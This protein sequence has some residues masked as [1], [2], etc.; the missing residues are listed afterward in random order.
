MVSWDEEKA[1]DG[2]GCAVDVDCSLCAECCAL[3]LRLVAVRQEADGFV[4]AAAVS[5][6]AAALYECGAVL[7]AA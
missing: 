6:A 7:Q 5:R 3:E 1:C 2:C 4:A